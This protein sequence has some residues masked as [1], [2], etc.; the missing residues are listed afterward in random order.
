MR[1]F[2]V[3]LVLLPVLSGCHSSGATSDE[4]EFPPYPEGTRYA[5]GA[6]LVDSGRVTDFGIERLLDSK[7]EQLWFTRLTRRDDHGRPYF[8]LLDSLRVPPYDTTLIVVLDGCAVEGRPDPE[9]VALVKDVPADS[10]RV[11]IGAW[12]ADRRTGHLREIEPPLGVA[13]ENMAW[14]TE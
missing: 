12:R 13:C 11:V 9:V 3:A 7:G 8:R 10:F 14:G 5:A 4:L 2:V 6:A 1:A